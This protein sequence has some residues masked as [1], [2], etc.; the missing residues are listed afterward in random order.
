[1]CGS[2]AVQVLATLFFLSYA[3]RLRVTVAVFQPTQ[4][5]FLSKGQKIVWN[6][7]GN[8]DYLSGQH[9]FLFV[10][11]LQ[12]FII[13]FIPYTL[14]LFG[15]Q[16]LQPIS[17]YKALFWVNKLKPLFDAYTGPYKDKHRYWTGL[18]LLLR[19]GLFCVFSANTTGEP[20]INLLVIVIVIVCLF[21]YLGL[22]G[23]VYK[24]WPLNMLEYIFFLNLVILSAGT[25]YI[26]AVERSVHAV[27]HVSVGTTLVITIFI[28]LY[29]GIHIF[30]K[31]CH[32]KEEMWTLT[33]IIS[34][35][36]NN[37]DTDMQQCD[38]EQHPI[39]TYSVVEM[40]ET[41]LQQ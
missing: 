16:W 23:G 9:I 19:I 22:L 21:A 32:V 29:H 33:R 37:K 18:L 31:K 7:D 26:T 3:K 1:M 6:Y 5:L 24:Y 17:H 2:N 13:F 41:L 4:L 34:R 27:T 12:F 38:F 10:F 35:K 8:L 39:V 28:V 30:V 11:T 20:A 25:L 40:R 14:A 36:R 15:I